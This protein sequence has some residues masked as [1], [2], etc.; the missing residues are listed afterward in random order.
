MKKYKIIYY[1]FQ[2]YKYAFYAPG[3]AFVTFITTVN[4]VIS[5][6]FFGERFGWFLGRIWGKLLSWMVPMCV[7]TDGFEKIDKKQSYIVVCNHQSLLDIPAIYGWLPV[8]FRWVMKQELRKVPFLGYYCYVA[9]HIFINRKDNEK[10]LASINSAKKRIKD[11]VCIL[12]FAEGTRSNDGKLTPFKKG[13]FKFALDM[14]LPI[15][16]VT[17]DGTKNVLPNNTRDLYPGSCHLNVNDPIPVDG[18]SDDTI[19]DLMER[20]RQAIES[21]F[22]K[23]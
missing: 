10:A 18:Y 8:D 7:K 14:G 4:L 22:V 1:P 6:F 3:I 12:F 19:D 21:G 16:P 2:I 15:L 9:G 20:T 17:I 23:E 11:G 13:A 5:S